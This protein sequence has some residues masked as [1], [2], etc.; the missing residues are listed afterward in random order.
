[1]TSSQLAERLGVVQS[2]VPALE[3][4]EA[5][6]TVTLASLEKAAHAMDCRLVYALVPRKP[7]EE[8]VEDRARLK[9]KKRLASTSH[10]M[11]LEAQSVAE[12]DEQEQLKRLTRQLLEK[13]GS[14]LWEDG[15]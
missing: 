5:R 1:M 11:A 6:K 13:A 7:L 14:D 3:Q 8:L 10:S 2:R 12:A 4:A 15:G 9:A